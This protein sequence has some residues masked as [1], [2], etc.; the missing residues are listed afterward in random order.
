MFD[1]L[2]VEKY[3][4]VQLDDLIVS[5]DNKRIISKFK[6]DSEI[7][8]LLFAGPP[9]VGK[10]TLAKILVNEV[11]GC[12]YLYINASD[13]N[14]IDTIRTKVTQFAQ[15]RSID[16]NIKAIILDECDGLSQDAQ[17][18]LRNTMEEHAAVTRFILT[19]NYNHRII[20]ALQSRCQT[21]DLTPPLDG[22]NARVNKILQDENI[23]VDNDSVNKL[24]A[25]IRRNYPDLRRI[26]NELQKFCSNGSLNIT[27][28]GKNE[29]FAR[30]IIG[31]T[32]KGHVL[33]VRRYVI[34]NE[35]RF[36]SDYPMLLKTLFDSLDKSS[37]ADNHKK[38]GLVIIAEA[39]YRSA[40]VVDQEINCYS[41]L[42]QLAG[43]GKN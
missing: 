4:P 39:L 7:P 20:P 2:W 18:A 38:M 8:N 10:T 31:L 24:E 15:T 11:L 14:G 34:E 36:N 26:I 22:C 19:A 43:M 33:K 32:L 29:E 27:D 3:R 16:G 9:G 30:Q 41:C 17:R 25:F 5:K 23:T 6:D 42:I 13:E 40:F 21:L 37:V 35:Q 28:T 1:S 12:Q